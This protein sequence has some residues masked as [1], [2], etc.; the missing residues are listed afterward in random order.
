MSA[1]ESRTR[2]SSVYFFTPHKVFPGHYVINCYF[3]R[4]SELSFESTMITGVTSLCNAYPKQL[5]TLTFAS[6]RI[7]DIWNK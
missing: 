4:G 1:S 6:C 3:Q 7:Y 2:T 5:L